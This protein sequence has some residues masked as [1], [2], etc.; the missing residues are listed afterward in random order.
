M[1]ALILIAYWGMLVVATHL[2]GPML[3]RG[4]GHMDKVL[5]FTAFCG[6][7][8]L[9][10][11]TLR[12]DRSRWR[13]LAVLGAGIVYAGIDEFTQ[14]FVPRRHPDIA[15]FAADTVGVLIGTSIFVVIAFLATRW[16]IGVASPAAGSDS[17]RSP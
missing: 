17:P 9:L 8:L 7:S 12:V 3:P 16:G 11:W 14:G 4:V 5:H 2:P 1:A 10:G 15:D 6:L 13:F